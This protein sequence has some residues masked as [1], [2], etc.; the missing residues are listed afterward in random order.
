M[1]QGTVKGLSQSIIDIL[2]LEAEIEEVLTNMPQSLG[3]H[4][5]ASGVVS[6]LQTTAKRHRENLN[7]R[8]QSVSQRHDRDTGIGAGP[9]GRESSGLEAPPSSSATLATLNGRLNQAALEYAILHV[10]A[11]RAYD[12]TEEGN[13]ADLAEAHFR[14]YVQAIQALNQVVSDVAVWD[15]RNVGQE[16][17]CKCPSCGLGICLCSPHGGNTVED[18]WREV[19]IA[20]A[21]KTADGIQVRPPRNGSPAA[22][23]GIHAGDFVV[24]VDDRELGDESWDSIKIMQDS[25]R[26]HQPSESV[27]FKLRRA[28]GALAEVT[29]IRE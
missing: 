20:K 11:H 12:S 18:I 19:F 26:K 25:I 13:T 7:R 8:L 14:D 27:H 1:A 5:K 23:A 16:C 9:K 21:A 22:R 24:A 15:Q 3:E 2:A 6:N 28:S 10:V 4:A 29:A 17:H